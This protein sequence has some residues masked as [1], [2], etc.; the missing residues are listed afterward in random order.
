[1]ASFI[2]PY[3]AKAS[4]FFFKVSIYSAILGV[5]FTALGW[6]ELA[7]FTF[8]VAGLSFT[9]ATALGIA[10]IAAVTAAEVFGA[11]ALSAAAFRLANAP[12]A[13][14]AAHVPT[15]RWLVIGG[16]RNSDD[17]FPVHRPAPHVLTVNNNGGHQGTIDARPDVFADVTQG[18]PAYLG[19]GRYNRVI[20]ERFPSNV[21]NDTALRESYRVL[22]PGGRIV[23]STGREADVEGLVAR[24]RA[25]GFT[26]IEIGGSIRLGWNIWG[27]KQ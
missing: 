10:F 20:F 1:V 18:L 25:V 4:I 16:G 21:I 6:D 22:V 24:L 9:L 7:K 17:R 2:A 12:S 5:G 23:I 27:T 26:N 15:G 19:T 11:I 14:P 3:L 13:G 8:N